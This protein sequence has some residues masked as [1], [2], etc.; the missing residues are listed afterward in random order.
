M[1]RPV[2]TILL[3]A[4]AL[5]FAS[6]SV[7][8]YRPAERWQDLL[9]AKYEVC[10]AEHDQRMAD[11]DARIGRLDVAR[12]DNEIEIRTVQARGTDARNQE[13]IDQLIAARAELRLQIA[14]LRNGRPAYERESRRE[15]IACIKRVDAERAAAE[16]AKSKKTKVII[17]PIKKSSTVI[18]GSGSTRYVTRTTRGVGSR[19]VTTGRGVGSRGYGTRGIGSRGYGSRGIGYGTRGIGNR[20]TGNRGV[21]SRC[22]HQPGTSRTHCGS[23]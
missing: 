21:G 22:H 14:R 2:S 17:K 1:R 9:R 6:P 23:G 13:R 20:G 15:L 11:Y 7:A 8:E 5:L 16:K 4:A 18:R 3:A 19:Y 12:A 10:Y